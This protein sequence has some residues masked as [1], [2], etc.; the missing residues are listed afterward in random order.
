MKPSDQQV[1]LVQRG[2]ALDQLVLL[3]QRDPKA[4][5]AYKATTARP[6]RLVPWVCLGQLV[7]WVLPE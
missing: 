6:G 2:L 1:R 3:A 4:Y 5:K 7:P